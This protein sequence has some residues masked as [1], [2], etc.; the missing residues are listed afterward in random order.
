[1][2]RHP[3]NLQNKKKNKKQVIFKLLFLKVTSI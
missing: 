3:R 1:M 2:S